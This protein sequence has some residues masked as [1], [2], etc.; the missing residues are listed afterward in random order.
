MAPISP[1][2]TNKV[3]W[4]E[5]R[6]PYTSMHRMIY[7]NNTCTAAGTLAHK[8]SHTPSTAT[9]H[10]PS[11]YMQHLYVNMFILT[12]ICRWIAEEC[13]VC[14]GTSV[15]ARSVTPWD[16]LAFASGPA[17]E[18]TP[19]WHPSLGNTHRIIFYSWISPD[20]HPGLERHFH[21]SV[22]GYKHSISD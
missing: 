17:L 13:Q 14:W 1:S 7:I 6:L 18:N 8:S 12:E 11:R 21:T 5:V 20:L 2:N 3:S 9:A 10:F 19:N 15:P 16:L 22:V 4:K